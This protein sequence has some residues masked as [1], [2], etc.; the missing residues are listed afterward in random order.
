MDWRRTDEKTA[1]AVGRQEE[2]S[3]LFVKYF[4]TLEK[5]KKLK[6]K[7]LWRRTKKNS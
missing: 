5:E 2:R 4:N 3:D 1:P 7:S 6:L